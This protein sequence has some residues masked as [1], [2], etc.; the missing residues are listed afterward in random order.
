MKSILLTL[1][2]LFSSTI[3][4]AQGQPASA[5][6]EINRLFV[7]LEQSGC[8]FYRNGMWHT[9]RQ[10]TRHLRRKYDYLVK[11]GLVTTAESFIDL[12]GTMSSASGRPYMVKCPGTAAVQGK[13]WLTAKLAAIRKAGAGTNN[14]FKP[15]PLRGS[16]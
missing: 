9:S 7:V 10:A 5:T 2:L 6:R 14:S 8:Q 16:A 15:H 3:A 1:L 11:K 4:A 13:A 12:A